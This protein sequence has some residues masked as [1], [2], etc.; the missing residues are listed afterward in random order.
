MGI[1]F[2]LVHEIDVRRAHGDAAVRRSA[3]VETLHAA[4]K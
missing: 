3:A 4:E 2:E 1:F